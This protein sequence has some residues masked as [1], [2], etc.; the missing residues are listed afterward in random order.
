[1]AL[2]RKLIAWTA[3]A[4]CALA[5]SQ[6]AAQPFPARP[7][8]IIVPF[9]PG[10]GT[11][12]LARVVGER[13]G[14]LLGVT[15]LIENREGAGGLVGATATARS[16]A[17]GYT[18]MMAANP[19]IVAPLLHAAPAYDAL[20][21]FAPVAKIGIL[22][23][24]LVTGPGA[25]YTSVKELIAYA[26]ANPGKLNYASSGKGTPSHLEMELIAQSAG[27]Q[28]QDVPYK[29]TAQAMTDTLGGQVALYFSTL[30]PALAQMRSSRLR[31]LGVGSPRRVA[32]APEIPTLA[33]ALGQPGYEANVWYGFVAPAGTPRDALTR[34][35]D[36]ILRALE[37]APVRDRVEKS[38]AEIDAAG[39]D[40]FATLLRRE[41]DKWSTLVKSLGLATH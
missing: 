32:Q 27:L 20:R 1:M 24:A 37:H 25:P 30:P 35:A 4:M 29:S 10:T 39:S 6:A 19:F 11:D 23:M 13:V 21:D 40:V 28:I 14:E 22:P 38:G 16:P 31:I 15:V 18:M 34:L 7:I 17:D 36:A 8:R 12:L 2:R 33:E 9:G 5:A 26:K 3:L 41:N